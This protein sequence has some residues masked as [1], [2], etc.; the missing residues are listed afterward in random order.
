MKAVFSS[1]ILLALAC[2]AGAGEFH[3]SPGGND[4]NPGTAEKPFASLEKARDAARKKKGSKVILA[5]GSHRRTKTFELD[6][7]DSGTVFTG[8]GASIVGSIA[9]PNTAV[10]PVADPAILDRLLPEVRDKV[11]EIAVPGLRPEDF[12]DVGPRGFRRPYIPA[13]L[14]LI[15][16]GKPLDI[17]R[18]P[19]AGQP[20]EPMGKVID[21]GPATRWN[22][23]PARGG[24]FEFKTDRPAR[25]THA[26]DVWITGYF[27]N[28]YADN[29]VK[30]KG[31]N[32]EKKTITTVHPHMYGFIIRGSW[33]RW[34]ALNLLEEISV[35]GEF[36]ADRKTGKIYFF[37]PA[38]FDAAKS[39][40]EVTMMGVPLVAIEGAT[41]VVFDGVNFENSRGMG[42]YIER[43][44]NN[45]IQNCTLRNLGMVAISI[46][47]GISPDPDYQHAFT[48]K[49][50]SRALG[51]W[52]EHIYD[53]PT[54]DREAGTG[55]GVVNCEIHHIGAGAI[56]LGGGD[57]LSLTPAGNFVENC[58]IHHFNR[59]D[60]TYKGGVNIDGVG[61][62]I[63]HC[64]IHEA[65]A[66]ALYLHGND[67]VIEYNEVTRVMLDGDDMGAFYM[68]RDPTERGNIIRYNYWHHLAP[69]HMTWCLYFDDS[70]GDST[71]VYG[72]VFLKAGN[73]SSVFVAGG[74]DFVVE[75]NVFIDCK[76]PIEPQGFRANNF[77]IF[78]Q[79]MAQ[80]GWDRAPWT[81]RYPEFAGYIEAKRPRN[82][83]F[84]NN[85]VV[86]QN[87]PRFVDGAAGN[88][89]LK[90][91]ADTGIAG[92]QP[93]PFDK[94]GLKNKAAKEAAKPAVAPPAEVKTSASDEKLGLTTAVGGQWKFYPAANRDPALPRVLLIGDSI[95]GGYRGA[96]IR[97][98]KGKASVDVWLTPVCES[99]PGLPGDLEKVLKQGPYAVVHFNIGLH[100]WPKG[101]IA[102]GQY[103]PLMR[104]YV[105]VLRKTLPDAKLIWA[106]STP[107]TV[108]GKPAELDPVNNPTMTGRNEAAAK[109]MRESGIAVND[110]YGLVVDK[111]VQ[112]SVGDTAHWKP[113]GSELMAKQIVEFI[114]KALPAKP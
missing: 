32:L 108:K 113:A 37:P 98:L 22:E 79:R 82:N 111:R 42:V 17:A 93:I 69:A 27:E 58:D 10:K 67:H 45:R 75:N 30:V 56:S 68:G 14:E 5:P 46:G 87:D 95:C 43:G 62:R 34:T 76:R 60:R 66:L 23:K 104:N 78:K 59:W 57:R 105:A 109:I 70:G 51:S 25:W 90:P 77:G 28:G 38:G 94:I 6:A 103:E 80:V 12:G 73:R 21:K 84:E 74:S 49:P 31:F 85:L 35:P 19:D 99:D 101:R 107:L 24:I 100:G 39:T 20:G 41:G 4:A 47:K 106:S 18:W 9:A 83:R 1:T 36:M 52:H 64:K 8:K 61:N 65:P 53:N 33:N 71:K 40:L 3:V 7:R 89:A 88:F 26:D 29:T 86:K 110:L 96:V 92:F 11:M 91:G 48:G 114:N 55:H 97:D 2:F 102:D 13:P 72:N 50:I 81:E 63:A 15:V 16:D 112:L 44:A 54:F